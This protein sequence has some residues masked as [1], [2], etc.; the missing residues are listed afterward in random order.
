MLM[1]ILLLLFLFL[2]LFLF[3]WCLCV[4]LL[5]KKIAAKID[6]ILATGQ[7]QRLEDDKKDPRQIAINE[8]NRYEQDTTRN[9]SKQRTSKSIQ[10][11]TGLTSNIYIYIY[12]YIYMC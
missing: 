12:I 2:F 3:L 9:A 1:L 6:E 8:L 7:L 11:R 10:S 5:G 4:V